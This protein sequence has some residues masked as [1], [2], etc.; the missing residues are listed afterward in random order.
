LEDVT[1]AGPMADLTVSIVCFFSD[2]RFD[3]INFELQIKSDRHHRYGHINFWDCSH[4]R[5]GSVNFLPIYG[6]IAD[7]TV[8]L[9]FWISTLWSPVELQ[10]A[11]WLDLL[12]WRYCR[13]KILA[14][15]LE[16]AWIWGL[17]FQPFQRY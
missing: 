9:S 2:H 10:I 14:F 4:R 1:I 8:S 5:Y 7:L 13:C 15:W 3:F 6:Q 11:T 12:F 16:N 17:Y